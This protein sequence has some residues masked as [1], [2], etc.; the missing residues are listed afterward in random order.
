MLLLLPLLLVA[1]ALHLCLPAG[2]A[3]A[4]HVVTTARG[5]V[6]NSIGAGRVD[7]QWGLAQSAP[8]NYAAVVLDADGSLYSNCEW[9]ESAKEINKIGSDGS[10][11][12]RVEEAHGWSRMGGPAVAVGDELLFPAAV[13]WYIGEAYQP[14]QYPPL[15]EYW[16]GFFAINKT[17]MQPVPQREGVSFQHMLVR[18]SSTGMISAAAVDPGTQRLWIVHPTD[19]LLQVWDTRSMQPLEQIQRPLNWTSLTFMP[20]SQLW[21]VVGGQVYPVN[22][23]TGRIASGFES[24][25][26]PGIESA[27]SVSASFASPWTLVIADG[28][29]HAQQVL[30]VDVRVAGKPRLLERVGEPGGVW[31]NYSSPALPRG[32]RAPLR[33]EWLTGAAQDANGSLVVVCSSFTVWQA[34]EMMASVKSFRFQPESSQWQLQWEMEGNGWVDSG[35][36]DPASDGRL[37]YM[38]NCVYE[39]ELPLRAD[40]PSGRCLASTTDLVLYPED[41][42]LHQQFVFGFQSARVVYIRSRKYLLLTGMQGFSI[43][44]HRYADNSSFTAIPS[45]LFQPSGPYAD[46][47]PGELWPPHQP[48]SAY[49]WRDSNC[50]GRFEADEYTPH[51][52]STLQSWSVTI[53]SSGTLWLLHEDG[54]EQVPLQG[55]DDCGNPLYERLSAHSRHW[56]VPPEFCVVERIR[57]RPE[58][59]TMLLSGWD[60]NST[61][62]PQPAWGQS[63]NLLVF[64]SNWS[65]AER[66]VLRQ[67]P[68][69]TEWNTSIAPLGPA[70]KT[71]DWAGGLLFL[72]EGISATITV[73]DAET[74]TN[75][76][77]VLYN[78][79]PGD[80]DWQNGWVD[81]PDGLEA[82]QLSSGDYLLAMEDD[83]YAKTALLWVSVQSQPQL[84]Q[85]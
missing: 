79:T 73:M 67:T 35:S 51:N 17:D 37:L 77:S 50:N 9:E 29:L 27:I 55:F 32:H 5:W 72:V 76:S 85:A 80:Q 68:I 71:L 44:L 8:N 75:L 61:G 26:I 36:F 58:T 48:S 4:G 74:L 14:P 84:Q 10:Y 7:H 20:D 23:T 45:L 43:A 54:V 83:A 52:L 82:V 12:G 24:S 6:G 25:P 13:Q 53:D 59:D 64:Y 60:T 30:L 22:L 40:R 62:A 38:P 2:A 46:A 69:H 15:G 18:T 19:G 39:V 16:Y 49:S 1:A 33:F 21:G 63:G 81:L 65:T 31:G 3:A 78:P 11:Q 70:M 56:A 42:R 28:G 41:P 34:A 66:A 47:H 57:Y